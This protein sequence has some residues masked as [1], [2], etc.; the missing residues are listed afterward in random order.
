MTDLKVAVAFVVAAGL[1]LLSAIGAGRGYRTA[2]D[3]ALSAVEVSGHASTPAP[4]SGSSVQ[5][6]A[7]APP[8]VIVE[9]DVHY[10]STDEYKDGYDEYKDEYKDESG[11]EK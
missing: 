1:F 5:G 6:R 10:G 9:R 2:S 11:D 7:S 8:T 4:A 3:L